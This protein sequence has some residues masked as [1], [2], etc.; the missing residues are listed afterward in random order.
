MSKRNI[1]ILVFVTL[2]LIASCLGGYYY[3]NKNLHQDEKQNNNSSFKN[4]DKTIISFDKTD[5]FVDLDNHLSNKDKDNARASVNVILSQSVEDTFNQ[6]KIN[7]KYEINT[8]TPYNKKY[9][10][11][12]C[13]SLITQ[14]DYDTTTKEF[15]TLKCISDNLND[16]FEI[17]IKKTSSLEEDGIKNN[18]YQLYAVLTTRTFERAEKESFVNSSIKEETFQSY[19]PENQNYGS[20]YIFEFHY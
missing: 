5:R 16:K 14:Q 2:I 10:F 18:I 7:S 15:R 20:F 1:F 8:I 12:N 13:K 6:I 19:F 4:N 9:F 11:S 3:S 17:G